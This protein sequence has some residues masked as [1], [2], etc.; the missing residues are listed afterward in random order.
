MEEV[1]DDYFPSVFELKTTF[2]SL[3]LYENTEGVI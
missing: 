2:I 1:D 3:S